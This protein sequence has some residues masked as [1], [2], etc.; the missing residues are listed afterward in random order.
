MNPQKKTVHILSLFLCAMMTTV[1]LVSSPASAKSFVEDLVQ[2]K[3]A[4]TEHMFKKLEFKPGSVDLMLIGGAGISLYPQIGVA[5]EVGILEPFDDITI[6][7][8]AEMSV[9]YC[10]GCLLFELADSDVQL[11]SWTAIPGARIAAHLNI[12]SKIAQLPKLDPFIGLYGSPTYMKASLTLKNQNFNASREILY[13]SLGAL[14]GARW[15][16]NDTFYV[17]G[18]YKYLYSFVPASE[19]ITLNGIPYT[20]DY[21]SFVRSSSELH[22]GIGLRF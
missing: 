17:S 19:Q 20:V 6:S 2:P 12:L 18:E 1:C 11:R 13:V 8:G 14:A 10:L 21:N 5:L 22:I 16:L 3:D 15:M 9:G 4:K 7:I